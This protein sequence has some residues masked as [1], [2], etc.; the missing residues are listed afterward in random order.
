MNSIIFAIPSYKRCEKQ[1]TLEYLESLGFGKNNIYISTQTEED[2]EKY[3][4]KYGNRANIIYGEGSCVADNRNNLLNNFE[5]G[6]KILILDDD[7]SYIGHLVKNKL[8]PFE[9]DELVGFIHDAFTY[10][11]KNN[12]LIWTVYPVCN[13]FFMSTTIDKKNI[14]VGSM[15]GVIVSDYRFNRDFKVKED[16]EICLHTIKDGYNCIRFN[17]VHAKAKYKA[18]GGCHEVWQDNTDNI[19]TNMILAK[20]PKLI[21]RGKKKNSILMK[22]SKNGKK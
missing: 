13:A 3:K 16:F 15:M 20:Y 19:C 2:F 8:V 10:A 1:L 6:S 4:S 18:K 22:V 14:G 21:K 17:F 11:E 7:V 9:K 12:A 5:K